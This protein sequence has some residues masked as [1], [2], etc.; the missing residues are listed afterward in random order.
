MES[1]EKL[2]REALE[3]DGCIF[4][5][6]GKGDYDIWRANTS[7]VHFPVDLT[8]KSRRHANNVLELGGVNHR[9]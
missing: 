3:A 9:I 1:F 2:V 4:I 8:I 5:G 7:G 6:T